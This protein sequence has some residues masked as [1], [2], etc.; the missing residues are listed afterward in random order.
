MPRRGCCRDAPRV[1]V[2]RFLGEAFGSPSRQPKATPRIRARIPVCPTRSSALAPVTAPTIL[3]CAIRIPATATACCIAPARAGASTTAATTAAAGCAVAAKGDLLGL[4]LEND[5]SA[6]ITWHA[7]R[8][9]SPTR[10]DLPARADRADA[11]GVPAEGDLHLGK[12][13]VA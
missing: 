8:V 12:K 5:H 10:A 11:L 9:R 7:I 1:R 2:G 3:L 4:A 6:R 13:S